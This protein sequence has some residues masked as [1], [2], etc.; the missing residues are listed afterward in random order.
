MSAKREVDVKKEGKKEIN[1]IKNERKTKLKCRRR[2]M[3]GKEQ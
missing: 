3:C 1:E 2:K